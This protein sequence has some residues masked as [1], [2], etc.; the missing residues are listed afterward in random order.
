MDIIIALGQDRLEIVPTAHNAVS[1]MIDGDGRTLQDGQMRILLVFL[2]YVY[3]CMY[4][5]MPV[6]MATRSKT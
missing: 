1:I 5:Y 3:V 6:P 4:I 2:A